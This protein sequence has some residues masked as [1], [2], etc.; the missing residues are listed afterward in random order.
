M[1]NDYPEA[2]INTVITKKINQSEEM[3]SLSSLAMAGQCFDE[4]RN[5]N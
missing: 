4:V 5:A 1:N 3:P 2:V